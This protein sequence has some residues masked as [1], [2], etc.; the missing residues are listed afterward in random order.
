MQFTILSSNFALTVYTV[1]TEVK[2]FT[3]NIKLRSVDISDY[4]GY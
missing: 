4:V 3:K 2:I 1:F